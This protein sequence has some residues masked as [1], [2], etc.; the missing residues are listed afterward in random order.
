MVFVVVVGGT[1]R[2][3]VVVVMA[4]LVAVDDMR[5]EKDV[6]VEVTVFVGVGMLRQE[7]ACE[8]TAGELRVGAR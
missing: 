5:A 3:V 2:V 7:H 6:V 8:I 1:A 4:M